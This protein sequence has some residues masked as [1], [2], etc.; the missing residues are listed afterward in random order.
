MQNGDKYSLEADDVMS[1]VFDG[2]PSTGYA[3]KMM[4]QAVEVDG[5]EY[6]DPREYCVSKLVFG[7]LQ[8]T[9]SSSNA[10]NSATKSLNV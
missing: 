5:Y 4:Q 6:T 9:V 8:I 3:Y 2:R 7:K 10:V 1:D